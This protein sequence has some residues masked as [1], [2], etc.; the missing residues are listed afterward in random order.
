MVCEGFFGCLPRVRRRRFLEPELLAQRAFGGLSA[1]H[2]FGDQRVG[3]HQPRFG[4]ILD[5]QQDVGRLATLDVVAAQMRAI[6]VDAKQGS[7]E[8]L[9]AF[10]HHRHL[11]LHKMSGV[12]FEVGTPHQRAI[13]PRR[14]NLQPIGPLDR[15]GHIH[16]RRQR[17]RNRL[18]VLD[19]HRPV[20]TLGHDLHRRAG[21]AGNA[22]PHQPVTHAIEDRFRDCGHARGQPRLH[23]EP[24]F[25]QQVG[26]RSASDLVVHQTAAMLVRFAFPRFC[27]GHAGNK[28]ERVPGGPTLNRR[29]A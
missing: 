20:R 18:A 25:V 21:L 24:W 23:H 15:V 9:A 5:G 8:P 19:Q 4:D 13:D 28:K 29:S 1:P 17:A 10:M 12:A 16:H 2:G 14:R 7:A 6:A 22:H 27:R 11:H 26:I 3:E